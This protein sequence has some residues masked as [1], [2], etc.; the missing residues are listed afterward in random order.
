MSVFDKLS[1][2]N[3]RCLELQK[4]RLVRQATA[5]ESDK[6]DDEGPDPVRSNF[7]RK[8]SSVIRNR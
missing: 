8:C 4:L 3:P 1:Y 6:Q 2:D 7:S 5:M